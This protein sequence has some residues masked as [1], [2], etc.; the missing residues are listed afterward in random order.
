MNETLRRRLNGIY[1]RITTEKFLAARGIGNEIAFY[2]FDYPPCEE[3]V[4]REHIHILEERLRS[5]KPDLRFA[6]IGLFA[7]LIDY[8]KD[9]RLLEKCFRLQREKGDEALQ[10]ALKGVLNPSK[11]ANRFAEIVR[12]DT[13]SLVLLHGLGSA[14][15]LLRTHDLLSNLHPHMDRTPLVLFFPGLYTDGRLRLFG[16]AAQ[17]T[18]EHNYYRA[19]RLID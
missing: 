14:Y 8:L 5:A 7:F 9:R 4:V 1:D 13:L 12:P 15:P 10:E 19:L 2:V 11:V 17:S 6:S 3:L 16:G 18:E